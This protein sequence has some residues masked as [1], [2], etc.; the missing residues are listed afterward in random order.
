MGLVNCV[1]GTR[2]QHVVPLAAVVSDDGDDGGGG[3]GERRTGACEMC[4]RHLRLTFHHLVP[5]ATHSKCA[6]K[7]LPIGNRIVD[8]TLPEHSVRI[9]HKSALV[10]PGEIESRGDAWHR[11]IGKTLP[12]GL[13]EGAE[14]R[15]R[16]RTTGHTC[17]CSCYVHGSTLCVVGE[18]ASERAVPAK[19]Q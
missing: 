10:R 18:P 15:T 3:G 8:T 11:Y 2:R 17:A 9:N 6:G 12:E 1:T 14:W 16:G 13:P 19:G 4:S 7:R 5:K